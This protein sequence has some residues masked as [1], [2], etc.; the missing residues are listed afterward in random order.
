[1]EEMLNETESPRYRRFLSVQR[2]SAKSVRTAK[3]QRLPS[4]ALTW[5]GSQTP[6]MVRKLRVGGSQARFNGLQTQ[7]RFANF[8]WQV[9]LRKGWST[10]MCWLHS[11][12]TPPIVPTTRAHSMCFAQSVMV[13]QL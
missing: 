2:G 10:A 7:M 12:H 5:L 9:W 4:K 8:A 13:H 1:M 11:L 6:V 3:L